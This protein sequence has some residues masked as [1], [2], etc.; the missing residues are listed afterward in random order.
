MRIIDGNNQTLMCLYTIPADKIGYLTK[1]S[2]SAQKPSSAS[3][4]FTA[5]NKNTRMAKYFEYAKLYLL[6]QIMTH[7]EV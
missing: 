6:V 1:Y 3:I 4:N 5:T 2:L 7:K